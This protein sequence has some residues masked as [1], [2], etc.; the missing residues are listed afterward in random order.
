MLQ[1]EKLYEAYCTEQ[2]NTQMNQET[3]RLQETLSEMLPYK[4]YLKVEALINASHEESDKE[5]FYAGFRAAAKLWA[6]AMK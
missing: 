1:I 4:E 5:Y 3:I 6:E 2:S